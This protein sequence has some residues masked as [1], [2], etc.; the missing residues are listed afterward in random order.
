MN[1]NRMRRYATKWRR[2][3]QRSD[4]LTYG[5]ER[6]FYGYEYPG[7]SLSAWAVR[8]T[9]LARQGHQG[10]TLARGWRGR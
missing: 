10:L 4:F 8:R 3:Q 5:K 6:Y 1:L 2:Y 7:W 9:E